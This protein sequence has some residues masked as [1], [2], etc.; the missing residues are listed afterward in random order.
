[1]GKNLSYQECQITSLRMN[2]VHYIL[3]SFADNDKKYLEISVSI[4]FCLYTAALRATFMAL[5]K[6]KQKHDVY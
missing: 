4:D 2:R 3:E 6:Y 5:Y 1:M